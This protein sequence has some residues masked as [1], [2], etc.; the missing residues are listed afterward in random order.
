VVENGRFIGP[1]H[2]T[3]GEIHGIM[4]TWEAVRLERTIQAESGIGE[5]AS[6]NREDL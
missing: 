5:A 1:V 2:S 3:I 6:G 4:G